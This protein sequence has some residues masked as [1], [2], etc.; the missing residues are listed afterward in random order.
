MSP[1]PISDPLA[2]ETAT[3]DLENRRFSIDQALELEHQLNEEHDNLS[4][5]PISAELASSVL[6]PDVL[7][8]IVIQQRNSL[9][10]LTNERD[11][12]ASA[13]AKAHIIRSELQSQ[14]SDIAEVLEVERQRVLIMAHELN[15]AREKATSDAESI[16]MLRSKVEE[17]RR[18]VMRL[19]SERESRR[20]SQFQPL[21]LDLSSASTTSGNGRTPGFSTFSKRASVI[22]T[23]STPR[24]P[25]FIG[26]RRVSSMSDPGLTPDASDTSP[27]PPVTLHTPSELATSSIGRTAG[28]SPPLL[29]SSLPQPL[30]PLISEEELFSLHGELKALRRELAQAK[31]AKQASDSVLRALR[32]MIGVDPESKEL[33]NPE[34]VE[35]LRGLSLPP[36][37]TD[38]LDDDETSPVKPLPI[39]EKKSGWG[40]KLWRSTAFA[41]TKAASPD[42]PMQADNSSEI[43]TDTSKRSSSSSTHIAEP[44][45][46]TRTTSASSSTPPPLP[47]RQPLFKT[48]NL[49]ASATA[50]PVPEKDIVSPNMSLVA[51]G[52]AVSSAESGEDVASSLATEDA[53]LNLQQSPSDLH[54]STD[55]DGN[56]TTPELHVQPPSAV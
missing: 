17:S 16:A 41:P 15:A 25:T 3:V 37:P 50:P 20:I 28:L 5:R 48:F 35:S 9:A 51:E 39:E 36:L 6:D 29:S 46:L 32:E 47:P 11:E 13:L 53:D 43:T 38:E 12:L 34:Q 40:L 22:S 49:F 44:P 54:I 56:E 19:Q 24:S 2:G 42:P 7:A 55:L 23:S 30:P 33:P 8:T 26:H 45:A 1:P 10:E 31:E 4:D 21:Q 14:M 52:P 27:F 18:G